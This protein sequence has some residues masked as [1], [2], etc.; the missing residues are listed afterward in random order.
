[1]AYSGNPTHSYDSSTM[2][3]QSC[4]QVEED[5]YDLDDPYLI[6]RIL[7]Q[8]TIAAGPITCRFIAIPLNEPDSF[9]R[10]LAQYGY[11][12]HESKD[13]LIMR[14]PKENIDLLDRIREVWVSKYMTP[15]AECRITFDLP[16]QTPEHPTTVIIQRVLPTISNDKAGSLETEDLGPRRGDPVVVDNSEMTT[17]L[18]ASRGGEETRRTLRHRPRATSLPL[19]SVLAELEKMPLT[20]LQFS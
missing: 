13:K 16:K 14:V 1:M 15:F 10:N 20:P 18:S 19:P 3:M 6:P 12:V 4:S 11:I 2:H 7:S 17:P 8:G 9:Y 5:V